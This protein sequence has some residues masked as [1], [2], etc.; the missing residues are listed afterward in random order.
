MSIGEVF[1]HVGE[2][3]LAQND[4]RFIFRNLPHMLLSASN[5][6]DASTISAKFSGGSQQLLRRTLFSLGLV[7]M[8]AGTGI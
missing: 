1:R 7:E 6:F 4:E 8:V 5:I 2:L 3:L